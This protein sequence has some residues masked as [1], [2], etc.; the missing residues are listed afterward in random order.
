[1]SKSCCGS[2]D[3]WHGLSRYFF[4]NEFNNPQ[5]DIVSFQAISD[6]CSRLNFS[7]DSILTSIMLLVINLIT[8][9]VITPTEQT[10]GQFTCRKLKTMCTWNDWKAGK[11]KQ[12]NQFHDLQILAEHMARPLEE[13]DVILWLHWQYHVKRDG[14]QRVQQCCNGS[15]QAAPI[16]HAFAKTYSS[17]VKYP[18][19]RQFL[20]LKAEQNFLLFCGDAKDAFA[21]FPAPEFPAFMM[22]DNQYYVWYLYKFGRKLNQSHVL[23]VLR[24]RQGHLESGKLW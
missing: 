4:S 5:F 21:H 10:L 23:P 3:F 18:I 13:N 9:Q 17:C 20:A 6:F 15:K 1:M 14:Q 16:L 11:R 19:Q 12:L 24:V 22:I 2:Y 7:E 8:S